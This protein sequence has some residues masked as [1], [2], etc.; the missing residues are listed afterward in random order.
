MDTDGHGPA[1]RGNERCVYNRIVM[2]ITPTDMA[3]TISRFR[4]D[5]S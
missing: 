5:A 3:A 2:Y 1:W 4:I